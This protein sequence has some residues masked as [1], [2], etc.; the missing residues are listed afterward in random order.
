MTV[1]V[2]YSPY[3]GGGFTSGCGGFSY[4]GSWNNSHDQ[5]LRNQIDRVYAMY[6]YNCTGQLEGNE[7]YS[8]YRD[9][10]AS[11]GQVA[12]TDWFSIRQIAM[13]ADTNYDGRISKM[14]MFNLFKRAQFNL[15]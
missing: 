8:A 9:L 7:F 3:N 11:V 6:D 5:F 15:Y 2:G 1:S 13:Q 4:N 10:C 14:E 12:P